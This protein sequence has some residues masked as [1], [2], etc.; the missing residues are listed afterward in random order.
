MQNEKAM[1]DGNIVRIM[2]SKDVAEI[3]HM[4]NWAH[5]RIDMIADSKIEDIRRMD[6]TD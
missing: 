3:E 2:I 1:L 4:R 6:V 5:K